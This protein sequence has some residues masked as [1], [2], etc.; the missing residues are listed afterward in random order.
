MRGYQLTNIPERKPKDE[1][2]KNT[3]KNMFWNKSPRSKFQLLNIREKES[4]YYLRIIHRNNKGKITNWYHDSL[5][6]Q[7]YP[8]ATTMNNKRVAYDDKISGQT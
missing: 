5:D 2:I 4:R 3:I 7:D 6:W 1:E 8:N